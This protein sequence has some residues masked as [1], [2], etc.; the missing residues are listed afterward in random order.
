MNRLLPAGFAAKWQTAGIK[1]P[2]GRK[3]AFSPRIG[4]SLHRF[5]W[6]LAQPTGTW[7]RLAVQNFTPIGEG[8]EHGPKV[9]NFHFLVKCRPAGTNPLTDFYSCYGLLY[10]QLPCISVL[11]LM[12]FASQVTELLQRNLA[13]VI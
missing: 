8:W 9:Q 13:S 6:N 5:M 10:A 4:D 1:F 11:H 2:Q 12:W 3:S 7:V